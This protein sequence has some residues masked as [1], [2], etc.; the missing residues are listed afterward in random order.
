MARDLSRDGIRVVTIAPGLFKT[1]MLKGLPQDVQ[2]ALG[3]QIPFP[4][5]LAKPD[6]YA[7]LAQQICEK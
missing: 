4:S 6:E 7:M 3:K 2:D 5:R 1:P